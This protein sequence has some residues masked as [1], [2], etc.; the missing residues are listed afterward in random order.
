[1]DTPAKR[2]F[3]PY[4]PSRTWIVGILLACAV[5]GF[6][7]VRS[8]KAIAIT[9][10]V[11]TPRS[12]GVS[13]TT[14]AP[15]SL[16][17]SQVQVQVAN[18]TNVNGLARSYSQTLM[19]QGWNILPSTNGPRVAQTI[20]YF[21]PGYESQANTIAQ[22]LGRGQVTPLGTATPVPGAAHDSIVIVLGPD[23]AG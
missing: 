23:L 10:V 3:N 13:T 5:L 7:G 9:G 16:P 6:F 22:Y 8:V 4:E 11:N 21:T 1:M 14:I 15:S 17:R 12:H 20:I 19:T 2:T 18:G